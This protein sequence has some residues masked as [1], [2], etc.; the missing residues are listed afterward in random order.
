MMAVAATSSKAT[1]RNRSWKMMT[2][3][4]ESLND[5]DDDEC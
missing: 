4:S 5:D 2:M 3:L 1:G